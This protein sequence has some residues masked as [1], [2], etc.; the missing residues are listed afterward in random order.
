MSLEVCL[1]LR[2][3]QPGTACPRAFPGV[4]APPCSCCVPPVS[5]DRGESGTRLWNVFGGGA[6]PPGARLMGGSCHLRQGERLIPACFLLLS[7]VLS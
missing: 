4:S 5:Q 7:H 6:G 1:P 2:A 3:A